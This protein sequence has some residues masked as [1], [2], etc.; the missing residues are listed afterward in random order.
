MRLGNCLT[1]EEARTLWQLPNVHTVKGKR[2]RA[3]LAVLLGC[4]LRRRELIDLNLDH[5]QRREDYWAIVDLLGKGG[6]IRTV[7]KPGW[8][9]QTIDQWLSVEI[10]H[11]RLFR[12]VCRRGV[13]W[14]TKITE[15]VV[16]RVVK[17]YAEKPL[18]T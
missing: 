12:C 18:G 5:M 11:G 7:P 8:V 2:D 6:H 14:G 15:R 3:I 17:E 9:K 10:T 4:G 1:V 16:W 13:V